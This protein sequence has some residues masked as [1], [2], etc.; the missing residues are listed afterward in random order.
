MTSQSFDEPRKHWIAVLSVVKSF[1][2]FEALVSAVKFSGLRRFYGVFTDS[3][4]FPAT[5]TR[6]PSFAPTGTAWPSRPRA[7][8][9]CQRSLTRSARRSLSTPGAMSYS[10]TR[11]TWTWPCQSTWPTCRATPTW[12]WSRLKPLPLVSWVFD[13]FLSIRIAENA[14]PKEMVLILRSLWQCYSL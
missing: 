10:I 8:R 7:T 4:V 3:W 1:N 9:P 6:S 2:V 14:V 5:W 11:R 13:G 12:R